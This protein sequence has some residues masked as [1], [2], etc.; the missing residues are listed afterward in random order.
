MQ[1]VIL[2]C[3]FWSGRTVRSGRKAVDYFVNA[4]SVIRFDRERGAN[5][6]VRLPNSQTSVG[7]VVL[8]A[9]RGTC[10]PPL[11]FSSAVP[12]ALRTAR[13]TSSADDLWP[14]PRTSRIAERCND[15]SRGIHP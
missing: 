8:T 15:G 7:R 9:P 6:A 1:A 5:L 3:V 11:T 13:A 10:Q 14:S 4:S 2:F 12:G